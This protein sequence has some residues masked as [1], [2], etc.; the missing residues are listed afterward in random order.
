M[1]PGANDLGRL[2]RSGL[3]H[4]PQNAAGGV[5]EPRG[6]IAGLG[7]GDAVDAPQVVAGQDTPVTGWHAVAATRAGEHQ[8]R[9]RATLEESP[10]DG[11]GNRTSEWQQ[12]DARSALGP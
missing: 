11:L 10:G 4:R 6:R 1:E 2:P 7:H 5:P 12:A 9:R 8:G 3:T